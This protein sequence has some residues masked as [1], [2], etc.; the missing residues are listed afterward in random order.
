MKSDN[1]C[2]KESAIEGAGR[3]VFA[4]RQIPTGGL[5]SKCHYLDVPAPEDCVQTLKD[6]GI[7]WWSFM[8]RD[9]RTDRIM[10]AL[11]ELTLI[12]HSDT[13]NV[14]IVEDHSERTISAIATRDINPG[15]EILYSYMNAREYDFTQSTQP[16]DRSLSPADSESPCEAEGRK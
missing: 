4:R 8:R 15:D 10:L 9:G 6:T 11:G 2:V 5:V 16:A 1:L 12:N 7:Y 3:G 13:P 14:C